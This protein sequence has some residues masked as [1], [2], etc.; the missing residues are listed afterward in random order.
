MQGGEASGREEHFSSV[1]LDVALWASRMLGTSVEQLALCLWGGGVSGVTAVMDTL[2]TL[3]LGWLF[4]AV[5]ILVLVK[6]LYDRFLR[7]SDEE[8]L[9]FS[10]PSEVEGK[11]AS[12]VARVAAAAAESELERQK[13]IRRAPTIVPAAGSVP[14][15]GSGDA[16][17]QDADAVR[18]IN[19][20]M[21]WLYR[22]PHKALSGPYTTLLN[23]MT[24]QTALEVSMA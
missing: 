13:L 8:E 22:G 7:S 21:H 14:A 10:E 20:V 23:E 1:F 18:W 4:S 19:T 24:A 11:D 2:N 9:F 16:A 17:G 6:L 15:G 12:E 3:L 5:L